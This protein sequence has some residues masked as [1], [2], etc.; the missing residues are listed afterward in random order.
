MRAFTLIE[1]IFVIVIAG[2]MTF[3]GFEYMPDNTLI[4]DYQI[5]KQKILQKK[6]N[7]LG[8]R[9]TGENNSTCIVFSKEWLNNDDN[10]S[11]VRYV[12]KSDISS[13]VDGN[14]ICFDYM[15]RPYKGSVDANLSNL[16]HQQVIV[17]LKYRNREKNITIY[18]ISGEVK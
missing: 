13:D 14:E 18:P 11:N 2:I 1:L 3:V 6:S 9:Y 5:L 4:S 15:G 16:L 8:Y 10:T 17:T 7:A 12:F